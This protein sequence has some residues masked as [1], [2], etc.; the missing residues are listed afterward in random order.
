MSRKPRLTEKKVEHICMMLPT[1]S[2]EAIA[3]ITGVGKSCVNSLKWN[4]EA[5]ERGDT[6]KLNDRAYGI[7]EV[8]KRYLRKRYHIPEP[9]ADDQIAEE[10]SRLHKEIAELKA[11]VQGCEDAVV[12]LQTKE[13]LL[14]KLLGKRA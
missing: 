10:M 5:L 7:G 1:M 9:G 3:E 11:A 13:D 6:S 2:V 14:L 8:A 4:C 12:A